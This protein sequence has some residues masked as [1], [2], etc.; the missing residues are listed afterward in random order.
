MLVPREE[1]TFAFASLRAR[2]CPS[3]DLMATKMVDGRLNGTEG[4][5]VTGPLRQHLVWMLQARLG[6]YR[7]AEYGDETWLLTLD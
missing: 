6:Q 7:I 5:C 3:S 2:G 4:V 1:I